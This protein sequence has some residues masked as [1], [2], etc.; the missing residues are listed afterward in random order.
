MSI[1][2]TSS[3]HIGKMKLFFKVLRRNY[4]DMALLSDEYPCA[5][6]SVI[7][8]R[9]LLHFVLRKLATSSITVKVQKVTVVRPIW[10]TM[11]IGNVL[12]SVIPHNDTLVI[13]MLLI[14]AYQCKYWHCLDRGRCRLELV[15]SDTLDRN[16]FL[17]YE[18][19]KEVKQ[20][21]QS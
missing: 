20:K 4:C 3:I 10:R 2:S 7:S 5:M 6:V 12:L 19:F 11:M 1:F 21:F 13:V 17:H 15:W 8:Q 9:F 14:T 18:F 16:S